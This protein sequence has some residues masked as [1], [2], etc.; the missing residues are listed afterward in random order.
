MSGLD[1]RDLKTEAD[2]PQADRSET[3]QKRDGTMARV[4]RHHLKD[5]RITELRQQSAA[6]GRFISPYR[7]GSA[8]GSIVTALSLLGEN[9]E[10]EFPVFWRK[11]MEV[12]DDEALKDIKTGMTPWAKF[13]GREQRSSTTGK[14]PVEKT[15]QNLTVLQRLGGANPY[16]YKLAQMGACIDMFGSASSPRIMLRTGIEFSGE[17]DMFEMIKPQREFRRRGDGSVTPGYVVAEGSA[18][19]MRVDVAVEEARSADVSSESAVA[20]S[21]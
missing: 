3:V 8:Y 17:E 14:T 16:G 20:A 11:L 15:I 10:H 4:R 5:E 6:E 12:M 1:Y 18:G 21:E 13:M 2:K 19:A 9:Q 7:Q